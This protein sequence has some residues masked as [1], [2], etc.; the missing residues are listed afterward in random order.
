MRGI[1]QVSLLNGKVHSLFYHHFKNK[2]CTLHFAVMCG[3]WNS[4]GDLRQA[5]K[6]ELEKKHWIEFVC[7]GEQ[8]GY[9]RT[10][11]LQKA[12]RIAGIR[13]SCLAVG[14][15]SGLGCFGRYFSPSQQ[16]GESA[17][18]NVEEEL[19]V[20]INLMLKG[21]CGNPSIHLMPYFTTDQI[22]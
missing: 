5:K 19:E 16:R 14:Y 11:W 4:F 17:Q 6:R 7:S 8:V 21:G 2:W 1:L 9:K 13:A 3:F 12:Q 18:R 10:A 22:L 15:E 20:K